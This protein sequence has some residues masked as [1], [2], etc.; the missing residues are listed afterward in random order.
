MSNSQKCILRSRPGFTL[1]E[2]MVTL[3]V[4]ALTAAITAP[5]IMVMAPNMALK[6]ATRDLYAKL[7]EAK[8]RAIKENNDVRVRFNGS[9]YCID[10]DNSGNCLNASADTYTDT[11]GDGVYTEG[12]PYN[13]VDGNGIFSGETAINFTDYGYDINRVDPAKCT[14]WN[15]DA[16][17]SAGVI[18]FNSQGTSNSGTIYLENEKED[19]CYAVSVRTAGSLLTRKNSGASPYQKALWD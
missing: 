3:A 10:L 14:N 6:S 12:E 2:V 17:N 18:T 4:M 11:N 16:C 13:D 9:H 15:N 1:V 5:S 7:Q 8:M 19:T